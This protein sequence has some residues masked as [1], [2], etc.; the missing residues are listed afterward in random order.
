MI[1]CVSKTKHIA[2][3]FQKDDGSVLIY[4][5]YKKP[6]Y[7]PENLNQ[8]RH[9]LRIKTAI[10]ERSVFTTFHTEMNFDYMLN[11]NFGWKQIF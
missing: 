6:D 2:K 3:I 10:F 4:V 7:L 1:D 11:E 9:K 8:H 5:H